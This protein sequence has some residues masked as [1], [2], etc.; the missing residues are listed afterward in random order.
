MGEK[1]QGMGVVPGIGIGRVKLLVTDLTSAIQ[2]YRAGSAHEE[3]DRFAKGLEAAIAELKQLA[4]NAR[5]GNQ[6][7]LAEIMEA[8]QI[9]ATDPELTASI[10]TKILQGL[11]APQAV[12]A[13]TVE[14][15]EVFAAMDDVYLKERAADL[16][17]IGRRIA[18]I[19]TGIGEFDYG[20]DPLILCAD[21]IEPSV[22]AGM[23]VGQVVG[24]ILGKGS[25]TSH[26][27]IIA[28]A[29]GI[30]TVSGLG[31]AVDGLADGA[32]VIVDGDS[33]Q[34]LINPELDE[35]AEYQVKVQAQAEQYNQDMILSELAA[36]TKDGHP[37]QLAANIGRPADMDQAVRQGCEGVGLFRSEFLFMGRDTAPNEDEQFAAYRQVV[38]QC[39]NKLCIIR[40]MDIGGDKPLPYL[41][42]A[43][44][45]NPFLGFRAI[46]ISLARPELFMTQLK[47]ILRAGV[48]GSV[49]IMLPMIISQ[50]EIVQA[51]K[52]LQQA[53]AELDEQGVEYSS[54]VPLGIMIETPAAAVLAP[55]LAAECDFFSIGTNDLVQYT[56]AVDRGNAA[57]SS[58]YSHFHPAV[59]NLIQGIIQAGHH[60]GIWVGMCGEMAGD[61]LATPLLTA[62]GIDELSMSA[63]AIPRVKTVIRNLTMEKAQDMLTKALTKKEAVD[64]RTLMVN[65]FSETDR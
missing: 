3:A 64:I 13:A 30:P 22:A 32:Q 19:L 20:T 29:Q 51:R 12:L 14:Y 7:E 28:K 27:I 49:A 4:D 26:T 63:P 52:Y 55:V 40:T 58:L 2:S 25:T 57:V 1:W 35:L 44:E 43:K 9:M 16:R 11:A 59:L 23:P 61:P 45:E 15:A 34:V 24:I 56:L 21:E 50:S 18:R 42:I 65:F 46:R 5:Q 54:D 48:Y 36:V 53:M 39:R 47:A 6:A 33:G 10:R 38:E 17:D 60:Q 37:I 41:N 8:H 62:M 31:S